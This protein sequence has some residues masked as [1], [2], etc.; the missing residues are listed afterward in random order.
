VRRKSALTGPCPTLRVVDLEPADAPRR[1]AI[2]NLE[3][4]GYSDRIEIRD[5]PV[6]ALTDVDGFDLVYRRRYSSPRIHLPSQ[7]P[8]VP[9]DSNRPAASSLSV[10]LTAFAPLTG[11]IRTA[12]PYLSGP[13]VQTVIERAGYR[14]PRLTKADHPACTTIQEDPAP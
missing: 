5:Q 3:A 9:P 7:L 6:E 1:E 14:V 2:A 11:R 12:L 4:A 13:G 8:P 10:D